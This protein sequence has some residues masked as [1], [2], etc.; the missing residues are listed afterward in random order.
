MTKKEK[1]EVKPELEKL[2]KASKEINE[3]VWRKCPITG[4]KRKAETAVFKKL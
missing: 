3:T 4:V 2:F 1:P